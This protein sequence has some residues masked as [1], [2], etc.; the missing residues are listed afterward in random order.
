MF[1]VHQET[2]RSSHRSVTSTTRVSLTE[3]TCTA[4]QL[5]SVQTTRLRSGS[6][7]VETSLSQTTTTTT[8]TL[9]R[10]QAHQ[11]VISSQ[12]LTRSLLST[13][14]T[15]EMRWAVSWL[16][17]MVSICMTTVLVR[18]PVHSVHTLQTQTRFRLQSLIRTTQTVTLSTD[19]HML[20]LSSSRTSHSHSTQV[21]VS[22][23]HVLHR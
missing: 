23:R 19:L 10:V 1:L 3:Q 20:R 9:T 21:L 15:S 16:T 2:H 12:S 7:L 17:D 6:R 14:F 13:L 18:M 8:V 4:T 5:V 22:R 11:Q